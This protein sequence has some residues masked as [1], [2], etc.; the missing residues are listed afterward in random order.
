M[1]KGISLIVLVITIVISLILVS[2]IVVN[3][4]NDDVTNRAFEV[5]FKT[6]TKSYQDQLEMY[7]SSK[8]TQAAINGQEY[9]PTTDVNLTIANAI[10]NMNE[11]DKTKYDIISGKLVYKGTDVLTQ[12]LVEEV[13]VINGVSYNK[14]KG[15]NKPLIP[16]GTGINAITYSGTTPVNVSDPTTDTWY[17]YTAST[18]NNTN[19]NW[20]NMRT[21]DGSIWVWIPRYAYK[22][23][24]GYRGQGINTNTVDYY[25]T[26]DVKFLIGTSNISTDGIMC[27]KDNS[28]D[29]NYIVHPAFTFDG[30]ELDGIWVAKYKA[31]S[32]VA[33]LVDNDLSPDIVINDTSS[34]WFRLNISNMFKKAREMETRSIYGFSNVSPSISI[35]GVDTVKNGIDTHMMK[36]TEWGA[37][38]YLTTSQYGLKHNTYSL[39]FGNYYKIYKNELTT[40]YFGFLST[41]G[42]IYG[43]YQMTGVNEEFVSAVYKNSNTNSIYGLDSEGA[44]LKN[45][46]DKYKDIYMTTDLYNREQTIIGRKAVYGDATTEVMVETEYSPGNIGREF[47]YRD[48]FFL[49]Y[50]ANGDFISRG[51]HSNGVSTSESSG[52]GGNSLST[53]LI[54]IYASSYQYGGIGSKTF[55]PV[56]LVNNEL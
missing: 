40:P 16:S 44:L 28:A 29:N 46:V 23:T 43:V 22:I 21:A 56:L 39:D 25:G 5:K 6:N 50:S 51:G 45:S 17:S 37:V 33:V 7:I 2:V 14:N 35:D 12:K 26:I 15:V 4:V 53:Y 52:S 19:K 18:L 54:G 9:N 34:T 1:K 48:A 42:N 8:K 41:T 31:R 24:S 49:P 11:I 47:W 32:S 38:A 36:N 27:F 55:R 3:L 30:I 10:P 13:G 20:A